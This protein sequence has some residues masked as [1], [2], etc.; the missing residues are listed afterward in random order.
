[1][2]RIKGKLTNLTLIAE[3][4]GETGFIAISAKQAEEVINY[5]ANTSPDGILTLVGLP[6]D[7]ETM[8]VHEWSENQKIH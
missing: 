6:A 7:F 8:T 4:N 2:S 3:I 1:M 5:I